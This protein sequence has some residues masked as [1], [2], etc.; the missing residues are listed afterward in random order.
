MMGGQL[1]ITSIRES[2]AAL[3]FELEADGE[4]IHTFTLSCDDSVES[5]LK[6]RVHDVLSILP[7]ALS[8]GL[9]PSV[10][11]APPT[12]THLL[13]PRYSLSKRLSLPAHG[14]FPEQ[15]PPSERPMLPSQ[16]AD[17]PVFTSPFAP[18]NVI[19]NSSA[20]LP[21]RVSNLSVASEE[22]GI[23]PQASPRDGSLHAAQEP[24][25]HPY[26][27]QKASS[28]SPNVSG[29]SATSSSSSSSARTSARSRRPKTAQGSEKFAAPYDA[30]AARA[31][32]MAGP[33]LAGG[34]HGRSPRPAN[35]SIDSAP[36]LDST[37]FFITNELNGKD[38]LF[39]GDVEPDSVSQSPRNGRVWAHAARQFAAGKLNTVFLECS[40]PASHPTEFLYGHLSVAHV[41]D[42]LRTMATG[43]VAERKRMN[44]RRKRQP[45]AAVPKVSSTATHASSDIQAPSSLFNGSSSALGLEGHRMDLGQFKM[46]T[47]PSIPA[48]NTAESSIKSE[49]LSES[50][51]GLSVV[52]IHVKTALFPSFAASTA[53]G[54]ASSSATGSSSSAST[55][56]ERHMD[57]RSMRDRIEDE[58][59][60][61]EE[62]H[63][64][65]VRFVMAQQG[66]RIEC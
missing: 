15:H 27:A 37:A 59:N 9:N 58:L 31:A 4:N 56:D 24:G 11:P 32:S 30:A 44:A 52:I 23:S 51:H 1:C 5:L 47:L 26:Q 29:G 14:Y 33:L 35:L 46:R 18:D 63:G 50:L 41:F 19:A 7:F 42:E 54:S 21:S 12:P 48:L 60:E 2:N 17:R 49:E 66:L 16:A 62:E 55:P 53:A 3:C 22:A 34:L 45:G 13:A 28:M 43:V 6:V 65:G 8:H 40:F 10:P 61:A 20:A 57:P 25:L 64:Y 39:F 36:A 38:V